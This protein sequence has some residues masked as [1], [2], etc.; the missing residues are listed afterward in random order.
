M[1]SSKVG[2]WT[3]CLLAIRTILVNGGNHVQVPVSV[4]I[5]KLDT[6]SASCTRINSN[7][8]RESTSTVHIPEPCDLIAMEVTY[9]N[10]RRLVVVEVS[11]GNTPGYSNTN[12]G[13]EGVERLVPSTGIHRKPALTASRC[14]QVH[15]PPEKP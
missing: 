3:D 10:I 4:D 11:N 15:R 12:Q 14:P 13:T 2:A 9:H 7:T 1:R 5:T 8:R 6:E